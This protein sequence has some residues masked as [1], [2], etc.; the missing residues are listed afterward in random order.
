MM[1]TF[2]DG[3]GVAFV[4]Y[5]SKLPARVRDWP[6]PDRPRCD[7]WL[8]TFVLRQDRCQVCGR[9]GGTHGLHIHHIMAGTV[10]RSDEQTNLIRLCS[11]GPD[12]GCHAESHGGN[13][14]LGLILWAKWRTDAAETDWVALALLHGRFLPELIVDRVTLE[15]YRRNTRQGR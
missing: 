8:Q 4:D 9:R 6:F 3:R 15:L 11:D 1:Q 7:E 10:G 12:Q 2:V 13:L 14:P 5:R